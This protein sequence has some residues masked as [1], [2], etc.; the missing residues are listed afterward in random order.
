MILADL[1]ASL[2]FPLYIGLCGNTGARVVGAVHTK[3]KKKKQS[4]SVSDWKTK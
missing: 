4:Q 1:E 3:K 2:P